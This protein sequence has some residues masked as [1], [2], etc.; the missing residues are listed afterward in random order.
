MSTTV[1]NNRKLFYPT[2]VAIYPVVFFWAENQNEGVLLA[3]VLTIIAIVVA[4]TALLTLIL[5]IWIQDITKLSAA[6]IVLV[7]VQFSYGVVHVIL[8]E[9]IGLSTGGV[10]LGDHWNLIPLSIAFAGISGLWIIKTRRNLSA[11]LNI[12]VAI[13]ALLICMN[14]GKVL[15]SGLD[16]VEAAIG[17]EISE[18]TD[19]KAA[20]RNDQFPDIY[21]IVLDSYGRADV[22]KENL[23]FDNSAFVNQLARRGFFIGSESRSNYIRT[24]WTLSSALN[25]RYLEDSD[26]YEEMIKN[27][28]VTQVLQN[29]GYEY[30]HFGSGWFLTKDNPHAD[31]R[32]L[33]E[34][35]LPLLINEFS[36]ALVRRTM[37]GSVLDALGANLDS[38]YTANQVNRFAY[39]MENLKIIPS[40]P[41]PTFVFNHNIPPHSPFVFDRN[42]SLRA[43]G[44]PVRVEDNEIG[45]A[46]SYTEQ[47]MWVNHKIGEVVDVI[48]ESSEAEPIIVIHGDHGPQRFGRY[49]EGVRSEQERQL[50]EQTAILNAIHLPE[51]CSAGLYP[52]IS[53][54]NTFRFIFDHCF[55]SDF[56]MI[57][58]WS[59]EE[60]GLSPV[61]FEDLKMSIDAAEKERN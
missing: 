45:G 30:V 47:I 5:R 26:S 18:V 40:R 36:H 52:T 7:A 48:L 53:P 55:G 44:K 43:Q 20:A 59:F 50:L 27:N 34:N 2:I 8:F 19:L 17:E 3:E 49:E 15:I 41:G 21:Y 32:F 38:P 25:M 57:E 60:P 1:I 9:K 22:L 42:G 6:V 13:V 33:G 56:G 51:S 14:A 54:V 46:E 4:A 31:V 29:A 24:Q 11:P 16:S 37:V 10:V 28:V 12:S 58:D 23:G 61:D 39:N 35:N